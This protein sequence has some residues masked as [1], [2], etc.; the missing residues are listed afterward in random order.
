MDAS[1]VQLIS[2]WIAA[3][4]LSEAFKA[5][6][7]IVPASQSIHIMAVSVVLVCALMIGLKLLGLSR[8][9]RTLSMVIAKQSRLMYA[10]HIVLLTTGAM[11]TIAEPARQLGSPAFW[12]K[13]MLIVLGLL[14]TYSLARSTCSDPHR[15]DSSDRR[16]VMRI[17]GAV[18]V[19]AWVAIIFCGRFIGYT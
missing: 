7:W 18:Y 14:M 16:P 3:T 19:S 13:M 9:E 6:L 12:V 17:Y 2:Y 1:V 15:W 5:H 11:L 10:G 8:S 4:S